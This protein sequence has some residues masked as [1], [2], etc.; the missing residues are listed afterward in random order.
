MQVHIRFGLSL[1]KF[2]DPFYLKVKGFFYVFLIYIA[3]Y[4]PIIHSIVL[5]IMSSTSKKRLIKGTSI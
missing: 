3:K 2:E 1:R 4:V 5:R